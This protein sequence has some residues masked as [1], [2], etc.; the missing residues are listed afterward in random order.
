MA[1]F[2]G[3]LNDVVIVTFYCTLCIKDRKCECPEISKRYRKYMSQF[4]NAV[5]IGKICGKM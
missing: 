2:N 4:I 3:V 5:E 1:A